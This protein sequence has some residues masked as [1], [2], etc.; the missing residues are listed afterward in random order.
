[1][2][3]TVK[4]NKWDAGGI[5]NEND[6]FKSCHFLHFVLQ[7]FVSCVFFFFGWE[8][9]TKVKAVQW[10]SFSASLAVFFQACC[11]DTD[12]GGEPCAGSDCIQL[13]KTSS[14]QLTAHWSG[15]LCLSPVSPPPLAPFLITWPL[16]LWS[17]LQLM[18]HYFNFS[19]SLTSQHPLQRQAWL[20]HK[21]ER[22]VSCKLLRTQASWFITIC[23][24][25]SE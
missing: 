3:I 4:E 14:H 20:A 2:I 22:K 24:F 6:T 13:A 19:Q 16:P 23:A 7:D 25:S 18:T 10:N 12:A 9:L 11:G 21:G 8:G 5:R 1:M 15:C 17:A